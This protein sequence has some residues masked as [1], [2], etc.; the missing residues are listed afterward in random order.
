MIQRISVIG[1]GK[2]GASMAAGFASRGFDVIGVDV[3][4]R[5]VDALNNGLAPVEETD[6]AS[7]IAAHRKRLR[8]TVSHEEAVLDSDISFVIVPTPSDERGSFSLQYAAYAFRELGKALAKKRDYHVIVLTSTV[9]P[10][11][12]R[13]G[14][15]PIL[16]AE[17]GK[18]CGPDFGLCYN[19]EFIALGSV[20]RD[21]L[22]PDFYLVGQFDRRSGD[23]LEAVHQRVAVNKAP[24]Q[25]LSLENAELAKIA[26]NSFVTLKIS[27]ANLL[28]GICENIPGGDV[29]VVSDAI[30]M[31]SRI[32]R[33]YLTGG[34][35]FGGPCFPRDNIALAFLGNAVGASCELL[36]S[37]DRFN[38]SLSGGLVDKLRSRIP[39]GGTVAVLGLAYK[40]H[41]HVIEESPGIYLAKALSDSGYRVLGHDPLA[42]ENA[43]AALMGHGLVTKDLSLCLQQ[44]DT[45]LVTTRDPA[46]GC[47]QSADFLPDGKERATVVDFWR[48]LPHLET[49]ARIQYF[50]LGRCLND[51]AAAERL[52]KLWTSR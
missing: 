28:A 43:T 30:G 39:Q 45:F 46:Y 41:S 4:Q 22:N 17:S 52:Q 11:S 21:F 1:L 50:P 18:K 3:S 42:A 31:D 44:A 40:P 14:L 19:P 6:L 49:D 29:D 38:R 48:F 33:K 16:E 7:T 2:L 10:G 23:T 25:R 37:N 8:A 24:T 9:L 20:I 34:F 13:Y 32:G 35:G 27:F 47:L 26:V 5:A 36:E 12:V 51:E 15:L